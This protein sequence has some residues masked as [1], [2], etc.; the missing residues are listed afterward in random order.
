MYVAT[1]DLKNSKIKMKQE[2]QESNERHQSQNH[3]YFQI[4]IIGKV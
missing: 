1:H 4:I 3:T 2:S